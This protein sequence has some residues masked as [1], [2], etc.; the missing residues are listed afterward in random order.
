MSQIKNWEKMTSS[1]AFKNEWVKVRKDTVKLPDG[2]IIPD[3]FVFEEN[4]VALIVPVTIDGKLVFVKQYKHALGSVTT[5]FPAGYLNENEDPLIAAE[6]ELR[7]ETGYKADK[8]EALKL[9]VNSPTKIQ[10]NINIFLATG[11]EQIYDQK[12]NQDEQEDIDI[13]LVTPGEALELIGKEEIIVTGTIAAFFLALNKL[14]I[15][16]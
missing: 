15:K 6:R 1:Y 3:F 16:L 8:F 7:E 5:E 12:E 10:S 11:C 13:L 9:V 14:E 2:K 4:N